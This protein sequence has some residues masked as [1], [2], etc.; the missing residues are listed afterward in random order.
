M[1]ETAIRKKTGATVIGLWKN[2]TLLINPSA[3]ETL[4]EN[5]ILVIIGTPD[6]HSK[7]SGIMTVEEPKTKKK[8]KEPKGGS[9]R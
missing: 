9:G 3:N 7:V 2:G 1:L 6:Q 4:P 5:S 8:K